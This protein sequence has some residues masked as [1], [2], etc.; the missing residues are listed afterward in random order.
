MPLWPPCTSLATA[1]PARMGAFEPGL[2]IVEAVAYSNRSV[3]P[4]Q[5]RTFARI[6][7]RKLVG[8]GPVKESVVV[9]FPRQKETDDTT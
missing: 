7:R 6:G 3:D 2:N 5:P 8:G 4:D 9:G 1:P